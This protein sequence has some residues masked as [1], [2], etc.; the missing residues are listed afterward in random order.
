MHAQSL[1]HQR[2]DSV[3]PAVLRAPPQHA[4]MCSVLGV[5][6]PR[7]T[8]AN[9][10]GHVCPWRGASALDALQQNDAAGTR[11]R[12]RPGRRSKRHSG[13]PRSTVTLR[14][15]WSRAD[16]LAVSKL[17]EAS[18]PELEAL[19]HLFSGSSL[20][21]LPQPEGNSGRVPYSAI[22]RAAKLCSS[23][24]GREKREECLL[25]QPHGRPAASQNSSLLQTK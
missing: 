13:H 4:G 18:A 11:R 25:S 24:P 21:V 22:T 20:S 19:L 10:T 1:A 17:I 5:S 6:G 14:R 12:R 7:C 2:R 15:C 23:T 9:A 3:P 8:P 16:R